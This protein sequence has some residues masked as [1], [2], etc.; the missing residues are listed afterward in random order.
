MWISNIIFQP[1][2][3][4]CC[5]AC[6]R[7]TGV[8]GTSQCRLCV[9][10]LGQSWS[11]SGEDGL[12]EFAATRTT[13]SLSCIFCC[14]CSLSTIQIFF[15]SFGFGGQ[16]TFRTFFFHFIAR[17]FSFHTITRVIWECL[18]VCHACAV[19]PQSPCCEPG[20]KPSLQFLEVV[21]KVV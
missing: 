9:S 15:P 12:D 6:H 2:F 20:P 19:E 14:V 5:C 11:H 18:S 17:V 10:N 7:V 13:K 16:P 4:P 1:I 3:G 21:E 8:G